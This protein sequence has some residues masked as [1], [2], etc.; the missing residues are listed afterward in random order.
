MPASLDLQVFAGVTRSCR[1]LAQGTF[2]FLANVTGC[3]KLRL[4]RRSDATPWHYQMC[5]T[6]SRP[7]RWPEIAGSTNLPFSYFPLSCKYNRLAL[8]CQVEGDMVARSNENV[9]QYGSTPA[10]I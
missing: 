10:Y 7:F 8:S 5:G 1:Q 6:D 3:D 4:V 9:P 2:L